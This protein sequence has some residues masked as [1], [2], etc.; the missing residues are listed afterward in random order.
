MKEWVAHTNAE[1][2]LNFPGQIDTPFDFPQ[3]YQSRSFMIFEIDFVRADHFH[4]QKNGSA[5]FKIM[6]GLE[7]NATFT[8][9]QERCIVKECTIKK[10][11]LDDSLAAIAH[12]SP[13]FRA[14]YVSCW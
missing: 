12:L 8:E 9:I 11:P 3:R 5:G 10:R 1:F 14:L 2:S 6:S 4:I 13:F 7:I